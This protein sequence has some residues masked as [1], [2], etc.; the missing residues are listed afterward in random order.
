MFYSKYIF[1]FSTF[2]IILDCKPGS[3]KLINN[4]ESGKQ[5]TVV[6]Y[7]TSLTAGGQWV[8]H[9]RL[10]LYMKYLGNVKLL[11]RSEKIRSSKWGLANVDEHVIK[12]RPDTVFIEFSINDAYL[13]YN[14]SIEQSRDNINQI[15]QKILKSNPDCEIIIM[16]MNPPS[17]EGL[18]SRPEYKKYDQVY[19][20][21]AKKNKLMLIDHSINW[22][23]LKD[24]D[25]DLY[26]KYIPDGLHPGPV[27]YEKIVTP[28]IFQSLGIK[29]KRAKI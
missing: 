14:I 7:G 21:A 22:L 29:I 11:N 18:K 5:Q 25:P 19:R 24:K 2:F 6:T 17:D 16:V 27:G 23:R 20:N 1:L 26:K 28:Q 9:L 8:D 13:P 10:A 15:I 4:L 12:Y 3:S